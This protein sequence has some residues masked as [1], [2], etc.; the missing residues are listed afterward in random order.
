LNFEEYQAE[1]RK[2][3]IYPKAHTLVY[4]ALGLAGEAGEFANKVKKILRGDADL[5][6]RQN[7]LDELGDIMWYLSNSAS[8]LDANLNDVALNNIQKLKSRM[9]RDQIKGSGDNR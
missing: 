4:P 7:L 6:T 5:K 9:E 1:A 8:D 2:T 3:A